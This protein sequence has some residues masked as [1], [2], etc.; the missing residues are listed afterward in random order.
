M[1]KERCQSSPIRESLT[2]ESAICQEPGLFL[3]TD[4]VYYTSFPGLFLPLAGLG[5]LTG[6]SWSPV[7]ARCVLIVLHLVVAWI[8]AGVVR[9][10]G[11][12]LGC[13]DASGKA[14]AVLAFML[15]FTTFELARSYTFSFW[16]QHWIQIPLLLIPW[17]FLRRSRGVFFHLLVFLM[18]LIEWTGYIANMGLFLVLMLEWH[19]EC[20]K[21]VGHLMCVRHF[22][23]AAVGVLLLTTAAGLIQVVWFGDLVGY[24]AYF[25]ALLD[26]GSSVARMLSR[27]S[28]SRPPR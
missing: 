7:S 14:A 11:K 17:M 13:D 3:R 15:S 4:G 26:R 21:P 10:I 24:D 12:C 25:A 1:R 8:T 5:W 20:R 9:E 22:P 6:W 18:P 16:G 2:S 23:R 28:N 27:Y 19:L